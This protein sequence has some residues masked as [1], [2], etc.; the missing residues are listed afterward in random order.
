MRG[1][2]ST[3][4]VLFPVNTLYWDDAEPVLARARPELALCHDFLLMFHWFFFEV[5]WG[6]VCQLNGGYAKVGNLHVNPSFHFT[7]V[8]WIVG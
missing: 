6:G 7:S 8:G 5:W 4:G 3:S 2:H 1:L